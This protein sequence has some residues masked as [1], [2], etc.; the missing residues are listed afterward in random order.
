M[1]TNEIADG[2]F[3]EPTFMPEGDADDFEAL[4]Q[5][6]ES[7]GEI[8]DGGFAMDLFSGA[9]NS[10]ARIDMYRSWTYPDLYPDERA[11]VLRNWTAED[12]AMYCG[13]YG[14]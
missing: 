2:L 3:L 11:A 5:A 7:A 1:N 6:Y 12:K 9:L 14:D 10:A 13:I 4:Q 8:P